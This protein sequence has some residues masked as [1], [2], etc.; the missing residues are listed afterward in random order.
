[1]QQLGGVMLSVGLLMTGLIYLGPAAQADH[2]SITPTPGNPH[3][4]DISLLPT[5]KDEGKTGDNPSGTSSVSVGPYTVSYTISADRTSVSWTSTGGIDAMIVKGGNQ[6]ANIY[7][8][9]EATSGSGSA[10]H[11]VI[12]GGPNAGE[13]G[14]VATIS[15]VQW[16][17][18]ADPPELIVTK[19]V[20]GDADPPETTFGFT[21]SWE[22]SF[23]E[24]GGTSDPAETIDVGEGSVTETDLTQEQID[25]GWSFVSSGC[26]LQ[27][28]DPTTSSDTTASFTAEAGQTIVCTFT[29]EWTEPEGEEEE[30]G[31]IVVEKETVDEPD[32]QNPED[33]GFTGDAGQ[34]DLSDGESEGPVSV[35]PGPHNV[36]ETHPLPEGWT[37]TGAVCTGE[38][39]QNSLD[40]ETAYFDVSDGETVTCTFTNEYD[41]GEE[42]PEDGRIQVR[43]TTDP[44]ATQQSFGFTGAIV[45]TLGSG[46]TSDFVEVAAGDYEVTENLTEAQEDDGW[47]LDS[48]TCEEDG[49]SESAS[50]GDVASATVTMKVEEGETVTCTFHNVRDLVGGERI[51]RPRKPGQE[52]LPRR[53]T[54]PAARV[55]PFTGSPTDPTPLVVVS[56]LMMAL[57]GALLLLGRRAQARVTS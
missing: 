7:T 12:Q 19:V 1:L 46:D 57:G 16:C 54:R 11:N 28:E 13:E 21:G 9:D 37:L 47:S 38:Q 40:G 17:Y 55:L 4:V 51:D 32:P 18:D 15:H 41:A 5:S 14:E 26:A 45:A 36:T 27:G 44:E 35:E 20:T 49:S 30:E 23:D 6:G 34:F 3:C 8:Y 39:S 22:G 24:G 29:N 31:W 33:F 25:A 43:K 48:I 50:E 52:V 2:T 53:V 10:P 56:G 42:E